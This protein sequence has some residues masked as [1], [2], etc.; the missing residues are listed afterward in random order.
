MR[1]ELSLVGCWGVY[2]V[3]R[4]VLSLWC[5]SMRVC[6]GL[7]LKLYLLVDLGVWSAAVCVG[8][9]CDGS[10]AGAAHRDECCG[11]SLRIT[12]ACGGSWSMKLGAAAGAAHIV[13]SFTL[14][15]DSSSISQKSLP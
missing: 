5:P 1:E 9:S 12:L 6:V 14:S 4:V 15:W 2:G 7:W 3:K 11:L 10:S 8:E 13:V